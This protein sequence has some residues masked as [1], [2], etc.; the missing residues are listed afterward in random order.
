MD[1]KKTISEE[2]LGKISGGLD[3][4]DP[5]PLPT[6]GINYICPKCGRTIAA[7]TRD[8]VVTCS[9]IR[10]RSSFQVKAGQL[11]LQQ[12]TQKLEML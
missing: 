4:P 5:Q 11:I 3:A 12:Q 1:E 9:N 8:M 7:S 6:G 2:E 10:C